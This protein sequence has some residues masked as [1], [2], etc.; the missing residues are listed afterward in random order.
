MTSAE[1]SARIAAA[2]AAIEAELGTMSEELASWHPAEGEW[3]VKEVLGH[4]LLS[5]RTGFSGRIAEI[6]AADEP[7]LRATGNAEPTCGRSLERMLAEF[8]R[9][10]A[11]SVEQVASLRESDLARGGVHESVG[12]LTVNDLLHE[13]VHHDRAHLKQILG[14]VQAYVWPALGGAQGFVS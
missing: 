2:G 4:L 13:W 1:V 6:L 8:R 5:E 9:Q 14:N 12:R 11:Q 3:C 7:R 10:R